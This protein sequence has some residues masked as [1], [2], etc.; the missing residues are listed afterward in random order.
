MP[1]TAKEIIQS[2]IEESVVISEKILKYANYQTVFD[3]SISDMKSLS[4]EKLSHRGQV[5]DSQRVNAELAEIESELTVL[6]LLWDAQEE[7]TKL[8]FKWTHTIFW[9]LDVDL[10]QRDVNRF[11]QIMHILEKGKVIDSRNN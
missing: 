9:N 11:M 7:W 4:L 5:G 1:K 2:L 8:Y 6:K 3:S 10:I